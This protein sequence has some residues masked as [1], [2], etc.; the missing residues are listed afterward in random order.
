MNQSKG[1]AEFA[2]FIRSENWPKDLPKP[3]PELFYFPHGRKW[4]GD[5]VWKEYKV[6]LEIQGG[7]YTRGGHARMGKS[8]QEFFRMNALQI[9]GWLVL[10]VAPADI[11][12]DWIINQIQ[13]ALRSRGWLPG[14]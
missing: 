4:R 1:E 2:L 14:V 5:Y 11:A 3:E 12:T 8:E 13:Q 9:G 7:Q 10:Q 6:A